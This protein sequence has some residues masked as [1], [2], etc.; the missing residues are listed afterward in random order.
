MRSYDLQSG[1]LVWEGPGLTL[2]AIPSPLVSDGVVY[3]TAG[4]R[5][6]AARA[7]RLAAAKGQVAGTPAVVWETDRD[8]PYV[9]SPL[10]YQGTLYLVKGNTGILSAIDAATGKTLYGPQRL[11]DIAEIY[12]SPVGAGG[13]VYVVGRDGNAVVLESGGEYKMVAKNVLD[14][15]FDASPVVVGDELY[16][17]G[18]RSLYRISQ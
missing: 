3:M 8:T 15:G 6:N 18:Y 1:E 14:D 12:A 7:I 5:G 4:F 10:L 16:L 11:G 9:P 13:R 17:R 2:N